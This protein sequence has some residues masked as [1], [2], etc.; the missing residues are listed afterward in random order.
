MLP[1]CIQ[2]GSNRFKPIV[3]AFDTLKKIELH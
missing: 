1:N 3:D 2:L